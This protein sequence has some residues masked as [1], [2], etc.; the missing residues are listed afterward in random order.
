[1]AF[2]SDLTTSDFWLLENMGYSPVALVLGNTVYSMGV[3]GGLVGGLKGMTKGEI[4]QY[5]ELMYN[6]RE[7]AIGRM[8]QEAEKLGA[9]GV[10]GVKLNITYLRGGEEMEI[11]AIGTAVK[12]TGKG[13]DRVDPTLVMGLKGGA[14]SNTGSGP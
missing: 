9:D 2:T 12:R 3:V 7:M 11:V 5:T 10:V 14:V 13:G 6:A 8:R 4:P 1:M